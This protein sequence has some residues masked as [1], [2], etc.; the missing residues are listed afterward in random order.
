MA[1]MLREPQHER[2]LFNHFIRDPF[3]LSVSKNSE[4]VLSTPL[5]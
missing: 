2:I 3:V 4:G 1:R 5:N